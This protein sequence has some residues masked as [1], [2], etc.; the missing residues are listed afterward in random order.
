LPLRLPMPVCRRWLLFRHC[1]YS[2]PWYCRLRCFRL[3]RA[4]C[5]LCMLDFLFAVLFFAIFFL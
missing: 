5:L 4:C 1:H 2:P 3:F